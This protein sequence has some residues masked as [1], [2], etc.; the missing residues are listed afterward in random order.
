[1]SYKTAAMKLWIVTSQGNGPADKHAEDVSGQ[2]KAQMGMSKA[3]NT[4][5]MQPLTKPTQ[6][7]QHRNRTIQFR[8]HHLARSTAYSAGNVR[9]AI[10]VVVSCA[11]RNRYNLYDSDLRL[12]SFSLFH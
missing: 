5:S 4:Q 6:R 8:S 12:F 9:P 7:I 10:D 2:V 11:Q 3:D 1:M